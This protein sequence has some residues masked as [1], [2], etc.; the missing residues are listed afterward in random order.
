MALYDI[1]VRTHSTT[2][3]CHT[4]MHTMSCDICT[5]SIKV[6]K[7]CKTNV[8]IRRKLTNK[9]ITSIVIKCKYIHL[10][11]TYSDLN[12]IKKNLKE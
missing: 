11:H 1:V 10:K 4:Y 3:L 12:L 7:T 2:K 9:Q 8:R 5:E 6:S